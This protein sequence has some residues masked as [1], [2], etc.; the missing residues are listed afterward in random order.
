MDFGMSAVDEGRQV[1]TRLW[2]HSIYE[3]RSMH[4]S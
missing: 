4:R 1:D 3:T 2:R